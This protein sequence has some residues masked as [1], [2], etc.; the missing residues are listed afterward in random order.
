MPCASAEIDMF[1]RR[2]EQV[3]GAAVD[4]GRAHRCRRDSDV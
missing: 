4:A 3:G 1:D 2:V